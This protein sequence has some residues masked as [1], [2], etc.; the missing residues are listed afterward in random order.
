VNGHRARDCRNAWCPLS[1][2]TGPTVSSPPPRTCSSPC[3]G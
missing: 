2:F 3:P 1:S